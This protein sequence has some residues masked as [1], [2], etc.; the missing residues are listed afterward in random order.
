ME[1]YAAWLLQLRVNKVWQMV[2]KDA[3]HE[4][5]TGLLRQRVDVRRRVEVVSSRKC[6]EGA[7]DVPVILH[8]FLK[9]LYFVGR[10]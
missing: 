9:H 6:A 1:Q 10:T 5:S 7:K 8:V 4:P 3:D 2:L